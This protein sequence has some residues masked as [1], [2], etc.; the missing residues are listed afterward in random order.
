MKLTTL[1]LVCESCAYGVTVSWPATQPI[2]A[3]AQPM[4]CGK[5]GSG[6]LKPREKAA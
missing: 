4:T 6:T 2:P 5:C 3:A 1:K